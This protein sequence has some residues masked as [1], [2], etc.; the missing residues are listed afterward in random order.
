M[1][2]AQAEEVIVED[3]REREKNRSQRLQDVKN[4]S[5][6]GVRVSLPVLD[7]NVSGSGPFGFRARSACDNLPASACQ[8]K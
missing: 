8:M 4:N 7:P 6:F 3:D 1:T 5:S 2:Q